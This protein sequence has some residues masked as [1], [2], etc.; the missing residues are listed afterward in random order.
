MA[1][2][3]VL[4]K[5][6][7]SDNDRLAI[8]HTD[9]IGMCHASLAAFA[10]LWEFGL[11]S[12]GATMVP[13][14]WFLETA[15]LCRQN[16]E[17]D[18]GVHITLTSEWETYRWGPISTR[19]TGSGMLD[20]QGFFFHSSEQ[21]QQHGDPEAVQIEIQAQIERAL[22]NGIKPTHMDTHMGSVASPKFIPAYLQM[23]IQYGL[24]PMIMRLKE[25]EWL[26]M[27]MDPG[28]AAMAVQMV[29]ELEEQGVP[30]LDRIASLE[31]DQFPGPVDRIS[32]AKKVLG[33]LGTGITHFIIH[34]SIDT[35]ELRAITPDWPY[36][37]ADFEAFR[38]EE[39]R[40]FVDSSGLHVIGYRDLLNLMQL[41]Q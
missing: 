4:K 1:P 19:D 15:K 11:I 16:P 29:A 6:G 25:E 21:A 20:E 12:S 31:L 18:M 32:Y 14:S 27:G 10:E 23:A 5:L 2:N 34:P 26:A 35:P 7:F 41:K 22:A 38:S 24:P 9:D 3:P 37:V 36:R 40:S 33:E 17:I 30:L 39:L 13:C 8:I 28:M